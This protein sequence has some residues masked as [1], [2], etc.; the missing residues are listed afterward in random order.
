MANNLAGLAK[1]MK[2]YAKSV[3]NNAPKAVGEV[4]YAIA[5][6]LVYATPVDTSRARSN[7]IG[8]IGSPSTQVLFS[9]P[10]EPGDASLGGKVAISSISAVAKAYKGEPGGIFI[11]NNNEYIQQLNRGSSGQAPAMFVEKAVVSAVRSLKT[12]KLLP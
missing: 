2:L 12:V 11:T 10:D 5:P 3:E 9:K 8:T 7:W 6:I 1:R 4:A